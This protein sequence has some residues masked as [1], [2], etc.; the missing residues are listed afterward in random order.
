MLFTLTYLAYVFED[1]LLLDTWESIANELKSNE[2]IAIWS[3][4]YLQKKNLI[5]E[6]VMDMFFIYFE[7]I[8]LFHGLKS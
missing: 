4:E 6:M 1:L 7:S 2:L 5:N 8:C 3:F